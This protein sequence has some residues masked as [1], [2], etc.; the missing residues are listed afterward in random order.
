[1][2]RS[3]AVTVWARLMGEGNLQNSY[4]SPTQVN[5][6]DGVLAPRRPLPEYLHFNPVAALRPLEARGPLHGFKSEPFDDF[7]LPRA[8]ESSIYGSPRRMYFPRRPRDVDDLRPM[9]RPRPAGSDGS[10]MYR[11]PRSESP[12]GYDLPP[13]RCH[14]FN[15]PRRDLSPGRDFSLGRFSPGNYMPMRGGS[16]G[17]CFSPGRESPPDRR[18]PPRFDGDDFRPMGYSFDRRPFSPRERLSA[19]S[20]PR[21]SPYAERR[22]GPDLYPSGRRTLESPPHGRRSSEEFRRGQPPLPP[23]EPGPPFDWRDEPIRSPPPTPPMRN[24]PRENMPADRDPFD[25]PR[26]RNFEDNEAFGPPSSPPV[27][28]PLNILTRVYSKLRA[29]SSHELT[30]RFCALLK[31]KFRCISPRRSPGFRRRSPVCADRY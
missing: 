18:F 24:G 3:T 25:A 17:P 6:R 15:S 28:S 5:T 10:L 16:P 11:S 29:R 31:S 13:R 22:R 30:P 12:V 14:R 26:F 9:N 19:Y 23:P 7:D 4:K 27:S 2:Q 1:M 8:Q 20:S 21:R